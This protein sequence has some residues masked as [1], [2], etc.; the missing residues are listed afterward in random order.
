MQTRR[1][2]LERAGHTVVPA[3]SVAD[4]ERAFREYTFDAAV[5]GQGL[6]AADKREVA[7]AIRRHGPAVK[8]LEL[9]TATGRIL[10]ADDWLLVPV[11]VPAELATRV[12]ALA[13]K[14]HPPRSSKS[15]K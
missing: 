7:K 3:Q 1:L 4:V 15:K 5:I 13:G 10:E 8:I 2:I 11:D 12:S 6:R 14:K 9:H